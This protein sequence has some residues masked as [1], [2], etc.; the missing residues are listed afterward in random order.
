MYTRKLGFALYAALV[1]LIALTVSH[2]YA[3]QV[4]MTWFAPTTNADGT[5]LTDLGGYKLYY[6]K[7]SRGSANSPKQFTYEFTK[8]IDDPTV[9]SFTALG[10]LDGQTYCFAVTAHDFSGNESNFSSEVSA[11]TTS[12]PMPPVVAFVLIR[13]LVLLP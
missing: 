10:L 2:A 6:G 3:A 7:I 8:I 11:T 9:A 12:A 13:S 5:P 1:I 4:Q